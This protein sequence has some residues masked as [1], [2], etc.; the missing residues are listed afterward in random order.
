[1]G[2][3]N[4]SK[5]TKSTQTFVPLRRP[6]TIPYI[7]DEM[8]KAHQADILRE[9]NNTLNLITSIYSI[10]L[11][12]FYDFSEEQLKEALEKVMEQLE[13][14][15]DEIVTIEQMMDL[16]ASYGLTV[17]KTADEL[18]KYGTLLLA[19]TKAFE[20]LD[21]GVTEIEDIAKQ[22][23]MSS[24][25]ASAF[26]WEW[27]KLKFGK[28]YEGDAYM[29]SKKKLAFKIFDEGIMNDDLIAKEINSTK[30]SVAT[31]KRDWKKEILEMLS[32]EEAAPYFAGE[33]QLHEI[34]AE[35]LASIKPNKKTYVAPTKEEV[36]ADEVVEEVPTVEEE[37]ESAEAIAGE[38]T[39]EVEQEITETKG[40]VEKVKKGL[41]KVISY[42]SE[43]GSLIGYRVKDGA[44]YLDLTNTSSTIGG[45]NIFTK[46]QILILAG[47]LAEIAEEM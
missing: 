29:V 13:L 25:I 41:K 35:K 37:S 8:R 16:C 33:K 26:R 34:K 30:A 12:E 36:K 31:Y 22:G 23:G 2:K 27:N 19:K 44:L 42:E 7:A 4:K 38:V 43:L 15:A 21:K 45:A 17:T 39:S 1:M 28:D 14:C 9:T 11:H 18:D 5:A 46:D 6:N 10:V 32:T 24:R 3:K 20:L 47:E 40:D